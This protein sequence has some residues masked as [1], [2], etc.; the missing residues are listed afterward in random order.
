M[1]CKVKPIVLARNS[2]SNILMNFCHITFNTS[3]VIPIEVKAAENLQAKSL[4]IFCQI[5]APDTEIR[6]SILYAGFKTEQ[7]PTLH[8]HSHFNIISGGIVAKSG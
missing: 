8:I 1:H 6:L 3:R 4:K 7:I 2:S 5:Y